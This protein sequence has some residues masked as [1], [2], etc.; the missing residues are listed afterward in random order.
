MAHKARNMQ[1]EII[2]ISVIILTLNPKRKANKWKKGKFQIFPYWSGSPLEGPFFRR[3]VFVKRRQ[4]RQRWRSRWF[5]RGWTSG[6]EAWRQF[7]STEDTGG[8]HGALRDRPGGCRC[9]MP[10]NMTSRMRPS[11]PPRRV[12]RTLQAIHLDRGHIAVTFANIFV[13]KT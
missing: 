2:K 9:A 3:G 13:E 4:W 11:R 5:A 8:P 12:S 1:R 6:P 7:R 10:R